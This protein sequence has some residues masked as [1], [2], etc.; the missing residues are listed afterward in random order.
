[1][2]FVCKVGVAVQHVNAPPTAV[3]FRNV[4]ITVGK[5]RND[6][7]GKRRQCT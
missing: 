7:E 6:A 3:N 2:Y 1:M 5:G 4:H